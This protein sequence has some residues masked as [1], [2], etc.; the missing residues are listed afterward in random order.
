MKRFSAKQRARIYLKAAILIDSGD[1]N[2][3]CF[4]IERITDQWVHTDNFGR[5]YP[6][7]YCFKRP[8]TKSTATWWD[9][10]GVG[11]NCRV[12]AL[13]FAHQMALTNL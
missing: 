7:F 13:L 8:H 5:W 6:E 1:F 9:E 2:A 3:A 11:R 10:Q 4:A 12:L